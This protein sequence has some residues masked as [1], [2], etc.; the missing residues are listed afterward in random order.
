LER[1]KVMIDRLAKAI[2]DRDWIGVMEFY[3]SLVGRVAPAPAETTYK[4]SSEVTPRPRPPLLPTTKMGNLDFSM[5]KEVITKTKEGKVAKVVTAPVKK[6]GRK[7]KEKATASSNKFEE[8]VTVLPIA[9]EIGSDKINDNVPLTPRNRKPFKLSK[10]KC[11]VCKEVVEVHPVHI[12][13]VD[14]F[15]CDKCFGKPIEE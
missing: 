14:S 4:I 12:R 5:K 11:L 8:L 6:K 13:D 10:V 15:R 9:P 3:T 7:P 2:E 1:E